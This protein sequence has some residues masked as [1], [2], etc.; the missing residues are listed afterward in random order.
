MK[1]DFSRV[2]IV[3]FLI[4]L[5]MEANIA[6]ST[7]RYGFQDESVFADYK[8]TVQIYNAAR[9]IAL[10]VGI[11]AVDLQK[12]CEKEPEGD[13]CKLGNQMGAFYEKTLRPASFKANAAINTATIAYETFR[14]IKNPTQLDLSTVMDAINKA[15]MIVDEL[16][17]F[18]AEVPQ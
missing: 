16:Q 4:G 9:D 8:S 11:L 5:L 18:N 12:S 14:I 17:K 6:C 1:R 15:K 2:L 7:A 3:V 10:N 13:A